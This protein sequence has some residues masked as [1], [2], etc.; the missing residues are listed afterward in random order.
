MKFTVGNA[1][2]YGRHYDENSFWNMLRRVAS[3]AGSKLLYPAL[4]LY[5]ML[6]ASTTPVQ[7]KALIIGALGYLVLPT[8]LVPDFIPL[9]GL[10]DDLTALM[11]ALRTLH[12]DITPEIRQ[13]ARE[14]TVRL[15]NP[16]TT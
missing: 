14:Q 13:K 2:Q 11:L 16:S 1:P 12:K 5:Y 9:M 10:T 15:L 4:Q 7:D 6:Q 8:D 3:T